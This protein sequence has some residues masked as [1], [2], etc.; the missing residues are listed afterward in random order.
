MH[1]TDAD[2]EAWIAR[3]R[4]VR[5]EDEC[6]RRGIKPEKVAANE[7]AIP[8]PACGGD[9]RFRFN[10]RKRT[11]FCRQCDFK[12]D[13]IAMVMKWDGT[14]FNESV[15]TLAGEPPLNKGANA[16]RGNGHDKGA[17]RK[18]D[19]K[20]IPVA[21]FVYRDKDGRELFTSVRFHRRRTGALSQ[22]KN[23]RNFLRLASV[24]L[25]PPSTT[26]RGIHHINCPTSSHRSRLIARS[27]C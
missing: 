10:T 27:R 26:R 15:E 9:D 2:R 5:I 17:D 14:D 22:R 11:G 20:K 24:R 7:C 18:A 8:C 4:D 19:A 3:A 23:G 1:T 16:Q 13:V 6:R 21:N 12:G 25:F